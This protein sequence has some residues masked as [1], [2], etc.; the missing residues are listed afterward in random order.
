MF[1][2]LPVFSLQ[3]KKGRAAKKTVPPTRRSPIMIWPAVSLKFLR[4]SKNDFLGLLQAL[5][6]SFFIMMMRY[7]VPEGSSRG[8]LTSHRLSGRARLAISGEI[9][10]NCL[11]DTDLAD[12]GRAPPCRRAL[13]TWVASSYVGAEI[14]A[15]LRGVMVKSL[16]W[17]SACFN[18]QAD[19]KKKTKVDRNTQHLKWLKT[20]DFCKGRNEIRTFFILWENFFNHICVCRDLSIFPNGFCAL[21]KWISPSTSETVPRILI[22][23]PLSQ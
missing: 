20:K 6:E 11:S 15:T 12:F 7:P 9:W 17:M 3:N 14:K 5:S 1:I 19:K 10:F 16:W 8:E 13:E 22:Y 4:L 2:N 21:W 23:F 18:E